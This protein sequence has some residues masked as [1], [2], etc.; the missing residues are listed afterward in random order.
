VLRI[1]S[2]DMVC[3]ETCISCGVSATALASSDDDAGHVSLV[4][5]TVPVEF[6]SQE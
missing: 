1:G 6:G 2:S 4:F 5:E 3:K